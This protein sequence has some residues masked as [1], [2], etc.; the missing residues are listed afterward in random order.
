MTLLILPCG[1][2]IGRFR[3]LPTFL[4]A[5][6][7]FGLGSLVCLLGAALWWWIDPSERCG[8]TPGASAPAAG[9]GIKT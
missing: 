8:E 5:V 9:T 7:G 1:D 6:L 3:V 4:I 2:L